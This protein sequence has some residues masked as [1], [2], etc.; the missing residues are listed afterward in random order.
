M[1]KSSRS[2]ADLE[3]KR[4]RESDDL[5]L[6]VVFVFL[7]YNGLK[8]EGKKKDALCYVTFEQTVS[9]ATSY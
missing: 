1:E 4:L 6:S 8:Q 3:C 7:Y 5:V 2:P 9:K